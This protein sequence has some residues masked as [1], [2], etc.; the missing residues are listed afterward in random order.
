MSEVVSLEDYSVT[1]RP[2]VAPRPRSARQVFFDRSEFNLVLN[3]YAHMVAK[4]EWRDYAVG[5]DADACTFSV[6][7]RS[8]DGALYRIVK[9]PKLARKQ[10]V[11]AIHAAGGRILKRGPSLAG[12]LKVFARKRLSLV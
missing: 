1:A 10:V 8:S 6:F 2:G 7:R 12:V 9:T 11:F 3:L 4:G 5:H